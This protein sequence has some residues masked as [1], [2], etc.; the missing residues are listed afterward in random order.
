[1][2]KILRIKY[3]ENITTTSEMA[4]HDCVTNGCKGLE[5]FGLN[6]TCQ[7]CFKPTFV[8]CIKTLREIYEI[9]DAFGLNKP[10]NTVSIP[11]Q[12]QIVNKIKNTIFASRSV[13]EF[14]CVKCKSV[15]NRFIMAADKTK[16][17]STKI[18]EISQELNEF[19][20]MYTD[21]NNKLMREQQNA[22]ELSAKLQ[23][24]ESNIQRYVQNACELNAEV[25][26]LTIINNDLQQQIGH[27]NHSD[28]NANGT[29]MDTDQIPL[30]SALLQSHNAAIC[31][32]VNSSLTAFVA[33]IE[34][35]L[36]SQYRSL[37]EAFN[38]DDSRKRKVPQDT[39]GI[40][41][42]SSLFSSQA[43]TFPATNANVRSSNVLEPPEE[44]TKPKQ[45]RSIYEIYVSKFKNDTT[46]EGIV[47]HVMSK[48]TVKDRDLFCVDL[49]TKSK[50]DVG[51]LSYVSFKITTC[52]EKA[53]EA[54]LKE[55]VWAP[56]FTAVPF[57]KQKPQTKQNKENKQKQSQWR[58][59][60]RT[61]SRLNE[62]S[63]VSSR[64]HRV[65]FDVNNH[66]N[67]ANQQNATPRSSRVSR[68]I[69]S[70]GKT[71]QTNLSAGLNTLG[72]HMHGNVLHQ[73]AFFGMPGLT[74]NVMQPMYYPQHQ[75]QAFQQ[76]QL[77]QQ[78][79]QPPSMSW[80]QHQ[81]QFQQQRQQ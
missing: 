67:N 28:M 50:E 57:S 21:T 35:S 60:V 65:K 46:T 59:P 73:P 23:Q 14:V 78:Q 53:Y 79:Q 69:S 61:N 76:P 41:S 37:L 12:Q 52:S 62:K 34:S 11:E 48:S 16:E 43:T 27:S 51:K 36:D 29:S 39:N 25:Q 70:G 9:S 7:C 72:G 55:D 1:M 38:V 6:L 66:T 44:K 63:G 33:R 5:Y 4:N 71:P 58:T 64:K 17:H 75:Q 13:F 47:Q 19:K 49:L 8:E 20:K 2:L 80:Q 56:K 54:I 18:Q 10:E 22:N 81:H 42:G 24:A 32:S 68:T 26:R 40:H 3:I 74:H 15:G 45:V 77:F 30:S 31:E